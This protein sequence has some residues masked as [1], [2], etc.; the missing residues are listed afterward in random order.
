[1][2]AVYV[3]CLGLLGPAGF[4]DRVVEA[5]LSAYEE[6]HGRAQRL[7]ATWR[8]LLKRPILAMRDALEEIGGSF[9][10]IGMVHLKLRTREIEEGA[11]L[12]AALS[13]LEVFAKENDETV[14]LI[15]DEFQAFATRLQDLV[16]LK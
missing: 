16:S 10:R 1:M 7:L 8:N 9:E 13:F 12:E 15:L 2:L 4:H 14:L 3:N 11:L 6:R 5:T